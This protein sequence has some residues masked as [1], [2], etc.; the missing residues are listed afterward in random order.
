MKTTE[1]QSTVFVVDDEPSVREGLARLLKS[2]GIAVRPGR[3]GFRHNRS[4]DRWRFDD[5]PC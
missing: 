4:L 3:G 2:A 5:L 1:R